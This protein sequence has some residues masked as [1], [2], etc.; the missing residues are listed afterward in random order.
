[1]KQTLLPRIDAADYLRLSPRTLEKWAVTGEGPPYI[2]VGS[3]IQY[4]LDDLNDWLMSRRQI[5]TTST[6]GENS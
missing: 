6:Y 4:L 2:R 5:S 3:R 1:M